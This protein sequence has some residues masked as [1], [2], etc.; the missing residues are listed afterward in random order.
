M[1]FRLLFS[2]WELTTF[3]EMNNNNMGDDIFRAY[4]LHSYINQHIMF[5]IKFI[6]CADVLVFINVVYM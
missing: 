1:F 6:V 5:I 4:E 3:S 2:L